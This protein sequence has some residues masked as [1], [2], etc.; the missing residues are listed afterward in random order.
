MFVM[1]TTRPDQGPHTWEDSEAALRESHDLLRAVAD[2]TTDALFVKGLDGRYRMINQAGARLLGRTV[3]EVLG[4]HD[5]ELFS[6]DTVGQ[7][8]ANDQLVLSTGTP[9]T[10]E[11]TVTASG[12]T[13]TYLST[14]SPY[15][16]ASGNIIGVIGISSD[17]TEHKRAKEEQRRLET[18][19]QQTQKLESLGLLAGGIAHDFNNL[20]TGMVGYASLAL[21]DLGEL[22]HDAQIRRYVEHI[23]AA[24]RRAAELTQQLLAYSGRGKFAVQPLSLSQIVRDMTGLLRVSISK[25]C[26]LRLALEEDLPFIEADATQLRQI[27]MNLLINASDA[28]GEQDGVIVVRTGLKNCDRSYLTEYYLGEEASAGPYVFL[29]VTDTGVGMTLDVQA[30]IFDPFFTT[31]ST[32]RGLGLAAVLGIVRGHHGVIRI[33]S[34]PGRGTLFT[35]LFPAH[36]VF[37]AP[38]CSP[39]EVGSGWRGSGT[40]LVVDDEDFIRSLAAQLLTR[41][42]F[43]VLTAANG[44]EAV[45]LVHEQGDRINLVLLDLTMPQLDGLET[46]REL[47]RIRP[48]LP[49]ILSSGYSESEAAERFAGFPLAAFIAKPYGEEELTSVVRRVLEGRTA[50]LTAAL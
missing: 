28:I 40:V 43:S 50:S 1:T 15:R 42:G 45:Q 14:K 47:Q 18:R 4:K 23:L 46:F 11:V 10:F 7:V 39:G 38:A 44:R 33:A 49:V 27:V 31:K 13:R 8:L 21:G 48:G 12:V 3:D 25:R 9:Q 24:A 32:G 16:D 2:G 5:T 17:I 29:E 34:E 41:L 37:A 6:P 36:R 22:P 30:K 26:V 19:V 35:V 20:L